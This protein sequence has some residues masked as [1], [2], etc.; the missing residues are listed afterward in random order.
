MAEKANVTGAPF[1]ERGNIPMIATA[2][3]FMNA[4]IREPNTPRLS[5]RD[6]MDVLYSIRR[7]AILTEYS[8]HVAAWKS[9]SAERVLQAVE[10][11]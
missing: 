7:R 2:A 10:E 6:T 4:S 8:N 3:S 11:L 1:V 9:E 5:S